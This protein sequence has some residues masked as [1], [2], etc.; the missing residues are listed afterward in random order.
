VVQGELGHE[1]GGGE[2]RKKERC[3]CT[4][5]TYR[6]VEEKLSMLSWGQRFKMSL[7]SGDLLASPYWF[8]LRAILHTRLSIDEGDHHTK[9]ID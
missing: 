8:S 5:Y 9:K 7:E 4:G 3:L 1:Q 6:S 2:G